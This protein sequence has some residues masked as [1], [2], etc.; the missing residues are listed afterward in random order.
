M[1]LSSLAPERAPSNCFIGNRGGYVLYYKLLKEG[2]LDLPQS[3]SDS[4]SKPVSE[5]NP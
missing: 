2:T 1:F 5:L 4:P 3:G